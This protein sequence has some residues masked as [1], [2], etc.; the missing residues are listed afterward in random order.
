MKYS[1]EVLD[2]AQLEI[3]EAY[4]YYLDNV[5]KK[6]AKNFIKDLK[7]IFKSLKINPFFQLRTTKFRAKPMKVFPY[8]VFFDIDEDEYVIKIIAVF[9]SKQNI[10]KYPS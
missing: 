5:S 1:I 6:V 9:H 2:D 7:S 4:R 3:E 10:N 8:L